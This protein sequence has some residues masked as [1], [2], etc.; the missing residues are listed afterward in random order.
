MTN[1]TFSGRATTRSSAPVHVLC[2]D[3]EPVVL[4]LMTR[5]LER[6]GL[7]VTTA[8]GPIEAL[9][10]FEAGRFDLIVTDIRM[11]GMDGHAFLAEIRVRDP[12]VPV[13]VATGHASLDSA[14]RAIRDGASGMLMKPFTGEE[15][16]A[17]VRAA[18]EKARITGRRS[19]TST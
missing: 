19:N 14:I 6:L 11:P 12:E 15:F 9:A 17:E 7:E 1:A 5:L 3:D 16:Q 10:F 2:V 8:T 4:L 18:L 13:V